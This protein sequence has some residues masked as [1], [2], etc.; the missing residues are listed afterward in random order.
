MGINRNIVECKSEGQERSYDLRVLI[1][2]L[3]N[4]N[5]DHFGGSAE[6][7]LRINR[8]IVECKFPHSRHS[9]LCCIVLIETLWNVNSFRS[10]FSFSSSIVLIE[11]LWNVNDTAT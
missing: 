10:L 3:W 8:N 2:T 5:E 1:E 7:D 4:V 6:A 9:C 11:T